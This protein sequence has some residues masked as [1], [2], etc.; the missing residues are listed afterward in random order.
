M[1]MPNIIDALHKPN[2]PKID[3]DFLG[4]RKREMINASKRVSEAFDIKN[5]T[6][7]EFLLSL[8][9]L[10]IDLFRFLHIDN[11]IQ[12][13]EKF[14]KDLENSVYDTLKLMRERG[15]IK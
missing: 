2:I 3:W 4:I 15:M 8:P 10:I 7:K 14:F 5:I 1:S 6:E 12:A 11:D 13:Q 9:I